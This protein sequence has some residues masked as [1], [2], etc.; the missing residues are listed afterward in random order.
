MPIRV[1]DE[2]GV[3]DM[4]RLAK[5][6]IYAA[7]PDGNPYT[8][9]GADVINLS[10]GTPEHADL[11]KRVV[12]AATHSR[13]I[14]DPAFP[15][16]R[17]AQA[18]VVAAAGNTSNNTKIYPAADAGS[19]GAFD[20]IEGLI[21]VGAS[22]AGDMSADFSTYGPWVELMAPGERIVSSIPGG[23][24]GVW[25][26]TSMAAPIVSGIVALVRSRW[27]NASTQEIREHLRDTATQC[28]G[29]IRYRVDAARAVTTQ[30]DPDHWP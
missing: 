29:R 18:I 1:L 22:T 4:W 10:L 6:L 8:H 3:G 26:G 27:P 2:N 20:S 12:E 14:S 16:L 30:P 28:A 13:R 21:P 7:D 9:D 25:R 11:V 15:Q 19:L 5:A 23:R 24:Y 17:N